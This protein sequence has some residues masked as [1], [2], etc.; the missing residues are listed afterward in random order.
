VWLKSTYQLV[1]NSVIG[2][3]RAGFRLK[4]DHNN[5]HLELHVSAGDWQQLVPETFANAS[6]VGFVD[7]YFLLQK[8]GFATY[9][10]D[11]QIALYAAWHL[12]ND[13]FAF[14]GVNDYLSRPSDPGQAIDTVAMRSPQFVLSWVHHFGKTLLA[15]GGYGRYESVGTWALAPVD[16]IYGLGFLGVQFATGPKTALLIEARRYALVGVPSMPGGLPPTMRGTGLI[17]DQRIGI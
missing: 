14:D 16:A 17:V 2:A 12:P 5:K 3:N 15:A 1:D 10:R 6:Q 13:D 8:N 4:Y 11:R 7:G 9:G